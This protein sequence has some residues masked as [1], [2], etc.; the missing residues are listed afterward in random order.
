MYVESYRLSNV[1]TCEVKVGPL[2]LLCPG[3]AG[4][5]LHVLPVV[6]VQRFALCCCAM[7]P[8][9]VPARYTL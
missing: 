9:A 7:L 4:R 1:A 5:L 3:I 2:T 8:C 6:W